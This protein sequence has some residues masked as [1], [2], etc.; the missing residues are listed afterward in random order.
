M[1]HVER[2][3]RAGRNVWR[4][5]YRGP[6][7]RERSK[8][9]ARRVDA[10]RFLNS[11]MAAGARGEWLDPRLAR[12]PVSEIAASWLVTKSGLS[13][14]SRI[15]IEARLRNH[16]LPAL[17]NMRVSRVRPSDIR[18][19][20]AQLIAQGLAPATV[21]GAYQIVAQMFEQAVIDDVIVRSPCRGI[22]LPTDRN[23]EEM[24]FLN[25]EE[26]NTL[27]AAIED[28]YQALIYTAAYGGLRAGELGALRVHNLQLLARTLEV[29]ESLAEVGGRL[30]IGPTKTGR[31]RTIGLPAFLADMLGAHISR[32]PARDGFV[33]SAAEGGPVRH[34]N[35][36]ARHFRPA[37]ERAGLNPRLRFHDLRHTCA[38]LLIAEGRH[39]EEIKAHLGHS[40][41]RVTSDRYGHLFPPRERPSRPASTKHFGAPGRAPAAQPRPAPDR[42]FSEK[43]QRPRMRPLNCDY[44]ER[45]TGFEPATLTLA[46]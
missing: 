15:N 45:T 13:P 2:R 28:R 9:F 37:V 20:V 35:F 14:R 25:A 22:E 6:D 1:A 11:V 4:A 39:L 42:G 33:F 29:Q 27:A 18:A 12:K 16:V 31:P 17:G 36:Y 40:T 32:Y 44:L 19:W 24:L 43:H 30:V 41:I 26:V 21:K 3:R 23:R 34:R 10:E 38:A 5:R 46:R 8:T 7:G